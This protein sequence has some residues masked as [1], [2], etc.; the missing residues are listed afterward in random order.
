MGDD[1]ADLM[2]LGEHCSLPDC[3]HLDFL[4]FKCDACKLVF[5]LVST[6]RGRMAC[7]GC[8]H[9]S[10]VGCRLPGLV[11]SRAR[12]ALAHCTVS[13]C[14]S[15]RSVAAHAHQHCLGRRAAGLQLL[16][17]GPQTARLR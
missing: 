4:P 1:D 7:V 12:S 11:R 15:C 17:M 3:M 16:G 14:S 6:L 13:V 2:G 9:A 8:M 10:G 5:C